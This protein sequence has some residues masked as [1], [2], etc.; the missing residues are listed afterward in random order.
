MADS[1]AIELLRRGDGRFSKRQQ[2]DTFRHEIALNFC[3]WLASW[4]DQLNLGD[5]FASHLID[6]TPLLLARDFQ[7]QV[8]SMLRPPGKQWFWHRSPLDEVNNAP[9]ARAYLDWRSTHMMRILFDHITGASRALKQSDEFFS[10]F[11]DAVL[12]VDTDMAAE[13]LRVRSY[14]TKDCVWAVGSENKVDTLTRREQVPARV[15]KQRYG[16]AKLHPKVKEVCEKDPDRPFEVRHEVLPADEYEYYRPGLKAKPGHFASVWID[17]ENKT[18]L[19]ETQTKTM[20][21]VVPRWVTLPDWAYAISPAAT[22]ALPDARLIQQQALAILEAAEKN[23]NPPLVAYTDT[24]RG[25][26]GLGAG[27]ITWVDGGYDARTGAPVEPLQ[28]G[29]N[30]ALG[31]DALMRT[32]AQLTR[33][34]YLDVLRMPDTRNSKSTLEVQFKIDEY[35]RAALP[36]FAPIQAEYND[37]LLYEVDAIIE[38]VGGYS[39]REKPES[40]RDMPMVFSWDNPLSDMLERQKAQTVAEV[41]QLGQAV[42]ALE[43]AA[44][45]APALKQ[46]DTGKMYREAVMGIGASSWVLSE[47]DAAEEAE[48]ITQQNHAQQ[49]AEAAPNIAQVVDS[50]VNAAQV[51][52]QIPALAEPGIPLL[53]GPE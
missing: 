29:K 36:L 51:A 49:M 39:A 27:A 44:Q 32:E 53:P 21:Y 42:A 30:F 16:E 2:L 7:G 37:A 1:N 26:V 3:P 5:D 19:R 18:V 17:V 23:V 9:D 52:G 10:F 15:M 40:L 22:V 24:V 20:R 50:G 35:V 4:T 45:Q 11:G 6:S 41:S 38:M 43:A 25:D 31:A 14:H 13:T 34:F 12:S 46:I 48:A 28:L 47:D 33:A 8:G